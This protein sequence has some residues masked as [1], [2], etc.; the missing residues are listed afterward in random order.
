MAK[1]KLVKHREHDQPV[2]NDLRGLGNTDALQNLSPFSF[3]AVRSHTHNARFPDLAAIV[4]HYELASE[5][6]NYHNNTL[7]LTTSDKTEGSHKRQAVILFTASIDLLMHH[8]SL[9]AYL[10][11]SS[12]LHQ[13]LEKSIKQVTLSQFDPDS[14][15]AQWVK[16]H[17]LLCIDAMST[18]HLH[19]AGF[20]IHPSAQTT[21]L[22][23]KDL[24]RIHASLMKY[25]SADEKHEIEKKK[26][27]G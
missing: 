10:G 18:L 17:D 23:R 3:L 25:V 22:A 14:S 26:A 5:S 27:T 9:R 19:Q 8:D 20:D 2:E 21:I 12:K 16:Q 15:I 4:S 11:Q 13:Y 6:S 1:L 7:Y 24:E